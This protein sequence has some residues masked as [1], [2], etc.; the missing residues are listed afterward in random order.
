MSEAAEADAW[1]DML[2]AMPAPMRAATGARAVRTRGALL[3]VAPGIPGPMFNRVL[4]L[5]LHV[6]ATDEDVGEVLGVYAAAGVKSFLVHVSDATIDR[7]AV[8]RALAARGMAPFA[9]RPTWAKCLRGASAPP[10]EPTSLA[11]REVF[12]EDAARLG[13]ALIAAHQMPAPMAAFTA[14]LVGR[15]CWRAYGAFDER[16]L[17][18]GGVFF[19]RGARAWLGLGGTLASHR[20]RGAQKAL[21]SR[22]VRDA[23]AAG[24]NEIATET[25]E[26]TAAGE[27]NPSL[28]NMRWCGFAV[29][30]S[31]ANWAPPAPKA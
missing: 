10:P 21:M 29:V 31:R 20:G 22:R 19:Q 24:A 2:G 3:L 25:G 28:A 27:P 13:E 18:A 1:E 23:I 14:A 30:G 8:E 12:A 16:A 15:P 4:G 6:G 7:E 5:G 26:P 17:V 9:P 11:V